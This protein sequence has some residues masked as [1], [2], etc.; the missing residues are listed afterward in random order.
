M[1]SK[2]YKMDNG[3]RK[4]YQNTTRKNDKYKDIWITQ[5]FIIFQVFIY[6]FE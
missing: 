3:N 5:G 2:V 4:S 1:Y 6:I